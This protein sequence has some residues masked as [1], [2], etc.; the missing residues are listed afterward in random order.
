M[1]RLALALLLL[2]CG[3][4]LFAIRISDI[5]F[6]AD[7]PI[8]EEELILASGLTIGD[9]YLPEKIPPALDRLHQYLVQK[10]HYYVSIP[11]PELIPAGVDSL[12]L[13]FRL[14]RRADSSQVKLHYTGLRYF[15]ESKLHDFIFTSSDRLY[16]LADLDEIMTR[17]LSEYQRRGYLF[18]SVMLDSLV[19]DEPLQAWIR[20]DEGKAQK[21]ESFHFRGN[22]VSRENY[23]LKITGLERLSLINPQNLRQAEEKLNSR[24]YIRS[25]SVTPLNEE[26][27]LIEIQEGRMT[28]L[29]GVLGIGETDGKRRISGMVNLEFLNL[30]GSDRGIR[31]FWRQSPADYSEL[32]FRYHESGF[33]SLPFEGDLALSRTMQDSL[34]IRSKVD[35]DIYYTSLKHKLGISLMNSS[36]LPGHPGSEI[37][38]ASDTGIGIF[39][40]FKNSQG[41]RIPTSGLDTMIEY[42]YF[43]GANK[44][45]GRLQG[46]LLAYRPIKG[47]FVG[48][49]GLNYMNNENRNPP[50]YD[51]YSMGGYASLRGYRED[52]FRSRRLG[53]MNLEAR[54]MIALETM[55]YLFYDQGF[56]KDAENSL[57][58]DQIGIGGGLK[59]GT[60]LGILSFEYGLGYRD[61][62]FSNIGL[63]MIHL[64]LDIA[65]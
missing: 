21:A 52:E 64:G 37:T 24:A 45:Y 43:P 15:S 33:H 36:I 35:A 20:V 22:K 11:L 46:K 57:I 26:T 51:L 30:W 58:Y 14:S 10:G 65:L 12:S 59:F 42:D 55:L 48:F 62:K 44:D 5:S 7:F 4:G 17:I 40:G 13:L 28:F 47:R 23:L 32:N 29:E 56:L 50:V 2:M 25:A 63:G 19:L 38:R 61:N 54:Y 8:Q 9:E 18:A 34:W 6:L 49:L 60:R 53:W 3:A 1:K 39:W 16:P 27:L 41:S 31:L